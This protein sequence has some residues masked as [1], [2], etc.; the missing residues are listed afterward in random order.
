[1][2][3]ELGPGRE[4][5]PEADTGESPRGREVGD[6]QSYWNKVCISFQRREANQAAD[7]VTW[8]REHVWRSGWVSRV[9]QKVAVSV[10]AK[11]QRR[12]CGE[13]SIHLNSFSLAHP[14]GVLF[15]W[16]H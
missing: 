13:G 2:R 14:N 6:K 11:A 16:G 4:R 8:A 15:T 7:M 9:G 1:M 5:S 3:S 12:G 10:E